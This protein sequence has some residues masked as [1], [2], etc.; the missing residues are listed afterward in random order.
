MVISH[1]MKTYQFQT[2]IMGYSNEYNSS[3]ISWY[4]TDVG[5]A[6]PF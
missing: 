4:P 6:K 2:K 3:L 5:K 1:V